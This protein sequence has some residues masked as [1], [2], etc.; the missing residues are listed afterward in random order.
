MRKQ[1][2][3]NVEGIAEDYI[4]ISIE[5]V[6]EIRTQVI[7]LFS[8]HHAHSLI[9]LDSPLVQKFPFAKPLGSTR[10]DLFGCLY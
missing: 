5:E 6:Q 8:P 7:S 1:R 10:R 4:G 9:F 2:S 3:K